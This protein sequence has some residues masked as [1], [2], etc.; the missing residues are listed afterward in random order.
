M[1]RRSLLS[2]LATLPLVRS[3]TAAGPVPP[4]STSPQVEELRVPSSLTA[5]SFYAQLGFHSVRDEFHGAERTVIMAL[6]LDA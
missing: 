2:I 6:R 1:N 5:E 4:G 3:A